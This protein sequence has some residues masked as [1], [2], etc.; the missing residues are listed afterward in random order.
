[1]DGNTVRASLASGAVAKQLLALGAPM[2]VGLFSIMAF[3]LMDTLFVARLGT[4]PLAAMGFIGPVIMLVNGATGGLGA[5]TGAVVAQAIGAGNA[6]VVRRRVTD[7]LLLSLLIVG[8]VTGIGY[9]TM[10]ATFSAMGAKDAVLDLV[11]R[12]MS[13]WYAGTL[14]AVV[15]IVGI[16]IIQATGD[17]K[18][19]SVIL[20]SAALLNAALDPVLIFGLFGFP[21]LGIAGAAVATVI[22]RSVTFAACLRV[23]SYREGLVDF[24]VPRAS[25]TLASWRS[26]G[27]VG[28]PAVV[29]S[30]MVPLF[31][32]LVIRI[33][34]GLG[35]PTVAAVGAGGRVTSFLLVPV[36]ALIN[37]VVP[38]VGQSWG[39]RR[40]ARV[41]AAHFVA[42]SYAALW[43]LFAA[44]VLWLGAERIAGW[45]TRDVRAYS[46]LLLYLWIIP[47]GYAAQAVLFLVSATLNA[48]NR[49]A[50]S[51]GLMCAYLF[52][53]CYP[54]A[55]TGA[56]FGST[57]GFF[58]SIVLADFIGCVLA[59]A[60]FARI[61]KRW[62]A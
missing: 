49:A 52:L 10:D 50:T 40:F 31:V 22:S 54:L 48:V 28:I 26:I 59:L 47:A 51:S 32:G 42:C 44:C 30:L 23:L 9:A 18:T 14:F 1:M 19:P 53:V 46:E 15:P 2:T 39:A 62:E 16:G 29:T 13:V 61:Q 58:G 57:P 45:L 6:R 34:A 60:C 20:V 36:S 41:R 25:E 43:S 38:L 55:A 17:A 12:Y 56:H 8:V 11:R 5:A 4:E 33:A 27:R 3:G 21:R 35:E 37:G 24:A 7:G